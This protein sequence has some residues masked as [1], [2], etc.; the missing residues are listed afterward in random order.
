MIYLA[1]CCYMVLFR[2]LFVEKK[3]F[4]PHLNAAV[5]SIKIHCGMKYK[6]KHIATSDL[7]TYFLFSTAQIISTK[8]YCNEV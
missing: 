7:L 2:D 3:L 6:R 5:F 8:H 4:P 1:Y